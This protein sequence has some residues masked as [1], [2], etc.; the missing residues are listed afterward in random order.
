MRR[1]NASVFFSV[2]RVSGRYGEGSLQRGLRV[3]ALVLQRSDA[4]LLRVTIACAK[5]S[6]LWN[7]PPKQGLP[8]CIAVALIGTATGRLQTK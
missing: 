4:A 7:I 8:V 6:G 5:K 1:A 2:T 3:I